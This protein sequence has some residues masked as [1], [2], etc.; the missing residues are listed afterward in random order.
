M[1]QHV[2]RLEKYPDYALQTELIPEGVSAPPDT[3]TQSA[4]LAGLLE[5]YTHASQNPRIIGGGT[6][7]DWPRGGVVDTGRGLREENLAP[8]TAPS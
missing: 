8:C 6:Q 7:R 4:E 3:P 1:K 2:E 5:Q